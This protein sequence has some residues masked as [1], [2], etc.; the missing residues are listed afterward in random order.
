MHTHFIIERHSRVIAIYIKFQT[1]RPAFSP[2]RCHLLGIVEEQ[3][4][5]TQTT[6]SGESVEFFQM[7]AIGC[8]G[9]YRELGLSMDLLTGMD[10]LYTISALWLAFVRRGVVIL[11]LGKD[12]LRESYI[13]TPR[14]LG[15]GRFWFY[16]LTALLVHNVVFFI[17]EA[18][19]FDHFHITLSRIV[20]STLF[21]AP[22][23][24]AAAKLFPSFNNK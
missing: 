14:S 23:V 12:T 24:W 13:P 3:S 9:S 22:F 15:A 11:S 10:G 8:V 6:N 18:L 1:A 5:S 21:T 17:F 7:I 4:A 2:L 16:V 20:V 19:T